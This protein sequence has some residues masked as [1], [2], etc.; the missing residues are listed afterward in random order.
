[1]RQTHRARRRE[2]QQ[3]G[4]QHIT[5]PIERIRLTVGLHVIIVG[6]RGGGDHPVH[7]A[8]WQAGLE[9][10]MDHRGRQ[11]HIR[12]LADPAQRP[13]LGSQPAYHRHGGKIVTVARF[14]AVLR[15]L[16]GIL[17]GIIGMHWAKFL[18]FNALGAVLWVGTWAGLGYLAGEHI[19]AIYSAIER[20]KWYALAAA[21]VIAAALITHRV[22]ARRRDTARKST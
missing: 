1:M 22:H 19:V 18:A 10:L 20:Y 17:S 15:Q 14:I 13:A 21:A 8:Q 5:E 12:V 7:G 6:G 3:L 4:T 9:D 11:L 16:N 2:R